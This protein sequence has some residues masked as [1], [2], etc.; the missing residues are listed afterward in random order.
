MP[1]K[2]RLITIKAAEL[3]QSK[4]TGRY[5]LFLKLSYNY[6]N[7]AEITFNDCTVL[8]NY[9]DFISDNPNKSNNLWMF[10]SN[11]FE[12]MQ[13]PI[14]AYKNPSGIIGH[15]FKGIVRPIYNNVINSHR[16]ELTKIISE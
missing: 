1:D 14:D 13:I 5:F 16:I 15:T 12:D 7:G 2:I 6:A 10:A 3:R 9:L 8:G 11:K 4:A